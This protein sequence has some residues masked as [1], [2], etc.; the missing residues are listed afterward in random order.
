ME[1]I[2]NIG[3]KIS[4]SS[5]EAGLLY[6]YLKMHPIDRQYIG[7]G[8]FAFSF[9]DFEQKKEFELTLNTEI[10][11]SCIRVLE[12]QDLNDPIEN[13]LKKEMLKKI[14]YWSDI[15]DNEQRALDE[16][17]NDYYLN[18]TEEFYNENFSIENYLKLRKLTGHNQ[19]LIKQKVSMLEK[20]MHFFNL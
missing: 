13:L 9:N 17:E 4:I 15:I 20:I 11:D 2:F 1:L 19:T 14:Y 8:H 5:I 10:I 12:D 16:L 18:S 7:K 3:I 6:K